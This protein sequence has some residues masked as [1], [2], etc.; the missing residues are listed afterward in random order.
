[1][2]IPSDEKPILDKPEGNAASLTVAILMATLSF[3]LFFVL[4]ISI[5]KQKLNILVSGNKALALTAFFLIFVF[6]AAETLAKYKPAAHKYLSATRRMGA[7]GETNAFLH[8]LLVF[9]VLKGNFSEKW[10][11][12]HNISMLF[13]KI[14][15][16]LLVLTAICFVN[17]VSKKLGAKKTLCVQILSYFMILGITLHALFLSSDLYYSTGR[18]ILENIRDLELIF[19]G[20]F[21]GAVVFISMLLYLVN[22]HLSLQIK[23]VMHTMLYFIAAATIIVAYTGISDTEKHIE[24][25]FHTN[26]HTA[27]YIIAQAKNLDQENLYR[28]TDSLTE[29]SGQETNIFFLNK[30]KR[31]THHIEKKLEDT[32]YL[33]SLDKKSEKESGQW[34]IQYKKGGDILLDNIYLL[35]SGQGYLVISTNYTK[36]HGKLD[37]QILYAGTVI[38]LI[39][40]VTGVMMLFFAKRNIITPIKK[41]T[42]TAKRTTEGDFDARVTLKTND[43]LATL[44]EIFNNMS[45]TMEKQISDLVRTDKLKNEFIAIASH[46]LRTPLTTLRGYMDMLA[47]E[48]SGKL[49]KKQK[50]LLQKADRSATALTS[51][52]EG[53]VNITSLETQG[54]KIEKDSVDLTEIVHEI[55]EETSPQAKAKEIKIKNNLG[56]EKIMTIG[57]HAKLKQALMA[58]MENA[59]KFNKQ[60]GEVILEKIIDDSRN[61]V[62]GRREITITVKDTGIGISK[63]E[64]E[65]VFQKFNRGTSTYTYEY[66]GVGLGLY[67]AKLII[68][69]HHGRIWFESEEGLGTTFFISLTTMEDNEKKSGK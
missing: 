12:E 63:N 35:E 43:E 29:T 57:D 21:L 2:N 7:I 1:M 58:V 20:I 55:L 8:M 36:V 3:I 39:I 42:K 44:A 69:A 48:K 10:F 61:P 68:Q 65:N 45:Q 40:L 24:E 54:V 9:F 47:S 34:N 38:F 16:T 11:L 22:K 6:V 27:E 53:L 14:S 23:I 46:N 50:D 4:Q 59:I 33:V 41:I 56:D 60:G 25:T 5:S 67:L 64:K 51:L 52:T 30:E 13:A 62:I 19:V 49:T 26:G 37:R 18:K 32:A 17:A 66:E 15:A 31:I 28:L